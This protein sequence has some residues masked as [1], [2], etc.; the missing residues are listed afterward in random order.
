[1]AKEK[2]AEGAAAP[3]DAPKKSGK[4][5]LILLVGGLMAV[6]GVG[7]FYV[8]NMLS[9]PPASAEAA[10][11]GDEHPPADGEHAAAA[12]GAPADSHGSEAADAHGAAKPDAHG[13]AKPDGH[14]SSEHGAKT[15]EHGKPADA[16]SKPGA[17]MVPVDSMSELEIADCRLHNNRTGKM[18]LVRIRVS[19]LVAAADA[20]RVKALVEAKKSRIQDRV[21][22]I[23]RSAEPKFMNE[24]GLETIKR[25]LRFELGQILG[26][27]DLIKE[28]LVPELLQT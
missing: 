21:S 10:E 8:A 14:G 2:P 5:K 23:I 28:I 27:A 22:S 3:A 18:I 4:L 12:Q 11:D 9:A 7:V 20:E 19:A 25:S 17:A 13:A 6:E 16:A 15:D 24:P 1:M 26:D